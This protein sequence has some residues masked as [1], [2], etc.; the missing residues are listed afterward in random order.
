MKLIFWESQRVK[1]IT[2]VKAT[3]SLSAVA[4]A[5]RYK[6]KIFSRNFFKNLKNNNF[7]E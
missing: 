1:I 3:S 2:P 6:L 7:K 5:M 4:T